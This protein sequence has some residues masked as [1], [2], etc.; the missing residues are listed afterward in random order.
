MLKLSDIA[1]AAASDTVLPRLVRRRLV[2]IIIGLGVLTLIHDVDHIR[3][4]RSLPVELYA[5][6]VLA[7]LSI[8]LTLWVL[9]RRHRLAGVVA[10]LQG[11]ATIVGVGAVHVAPQ[12][13]SVTDS[14]SAARADAFS[15]AIILAM[16][17]A[18]A[19]LALAAASSA[20]LAM[21][22]GPT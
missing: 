16:M 2:A 18:G 9:A 8:G 1:E 21:T 14:Y 3:Q 4:G 11:V 17:S 22:L 15:W 6:A 19:V 12:W 10:F 5:V 20:R 7:L 13:A